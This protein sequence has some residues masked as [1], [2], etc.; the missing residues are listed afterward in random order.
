MR[1]SSKLRTDGDADDEL[2]ELD[3]FGAVQVGEVEQLLDLVRREL[4]VLA[5]VRQHVTQLLQRNLLRLLV[6]AV[7]RVCIG[8][9]VS[10]EQNE[11]DCAD[12]CSCGTPCGRLRTSGAQQGTAAP[13]G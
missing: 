12:P 13:A 2:L 1:G 6:L 10:K 3:G 9:H 4:L 11:I 8:V 7:L 5:N